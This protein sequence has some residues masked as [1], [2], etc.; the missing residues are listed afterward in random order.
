MVLNSRY[1]FIRTRKAVA[2]TRTH[3]YTRG[4]AQAYTEPRFLCKEKK[5]KHEWTRKL[6]SSPPILPHPVRRNVT[7]REYPWKFR[8]QIW[9]TPIRLRSQHHPIG[10]FGTSAKQL[11]F[12]R[13][14]SGKLCRI[15]MTA[16]SKQ[17]DLR[18][19]QRLLQ[20]EEKT[21]TA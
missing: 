21:R 11:N 1:R 12:V 8:F 13:H 10:V 9:F 7:M 3:K 20:S 5:K 17:C 18:H 19:V 16:A 15:E 4:H 14:F 2:G 6:I